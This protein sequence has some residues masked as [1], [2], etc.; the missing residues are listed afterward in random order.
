MKALKRHIALGLFDDL[1]PLNETNDA[2]RAHLAQRLRVEIRGEDT[3]LFNKGDTG[4]YSV[5]LLEGEVAL[6][7]PLSPEERI[8]TNTAAARYP[9]AHHF[10]RHVTTQTHTHTKQHNNNSDVAELID[11][12]AAQPAEQT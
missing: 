12:A 5:Y 10:P 8:R 7:S 11:A 2:M 3:V 6:T 9:L 1:V 4:R